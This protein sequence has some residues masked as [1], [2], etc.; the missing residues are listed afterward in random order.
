[1]AAATGRRYRAGQGSNESQKATVRIGCGHWPPK[2]S[3]GTARRKIWVVF[4]YFLWYN[5]G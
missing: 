4:L 2:L 1:M 3:A 5:L